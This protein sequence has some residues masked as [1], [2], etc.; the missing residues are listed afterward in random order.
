MTNAF[1][2][3]A[4]CE[5]VDSVSIQETQQKLDACGKLTRR[6][7]LDVWKEQVSHWNPD[8]AKRLA[9]PERREK[10]RR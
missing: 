6:V 5:A 2:T 9:L 1:G 10:G 7:G 4:V 8:I 3:S